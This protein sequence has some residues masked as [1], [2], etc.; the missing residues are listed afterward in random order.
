MQSAFRAQRPGTCRCRGC[1]ALQRPNVRARAIRFRHVESKCLDASFEVPVGKDQV[2]VDVAGVPVSKDRM[3]VRVH[4]SSDTQSPRVCMRRLRFRCAKTKCL[5][6]YIEVPVG[7]DR[8]LVRV[9]G[10]QVRRAQMLVRMYWSPG[11]RLRQRV[12]RKDGLYM[13]VNSS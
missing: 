1:S 4:S 12:F 3:L 9:A 5:S 11:S 2:R 8:I 7:K 10:I 6:A 13:R